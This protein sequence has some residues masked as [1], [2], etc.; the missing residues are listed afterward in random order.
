[1][2]S[3]CLQIESCRHVILFTVCNEL[4]I[5]QIYML[6]QKCLFRIAKQAL[7]VCETIGFAR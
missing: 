6:K 7:F 4:I 5:K 1:M 2:Y 3:D